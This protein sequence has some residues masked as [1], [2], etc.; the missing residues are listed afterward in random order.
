[1]K[2]EDAIRR[3][4]KWAKDDRIDLRIR[5][6][7]EQ[8]AEWL[9]ELQRLRP[10]ADRSQGEW[11]IEKTLYDNYNYRCS[12][13]DWYETHAYDDNPTYNYCPHCGARMKGADDESD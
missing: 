10:S 3:Y 11:L 9:K 12:Y 6:E 1:M 5:K 2:I 7:H 13:C 8:I 4:E